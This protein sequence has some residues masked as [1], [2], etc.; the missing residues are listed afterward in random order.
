M[1]IYGFSYPVVISCYGG[2]ALCIKIALI[3]SMAV[4]D[5]KRTYTLTYISDY[6]LYHSIFTEKSV[7][8]NIE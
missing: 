4:L 1:E 5:F 7:F 3:E 2:V 6:Y 8:T